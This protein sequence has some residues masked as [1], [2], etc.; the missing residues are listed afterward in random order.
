MIVHEDARRGQILSG[1]SSPDPAPDWRT[2]RRLAGRR[3]GN[4]DD[5]GR[6]T[7]PFDV[8][9]SE[10]LDGERDGMDVAS[11]CSWHSAVR[12]ST[13]RTSGRHDREQ[14]ADRPGPHELGCAGVRG[15]RGRVGAAPAAHQL[16]QLVKGAADTELD[17]SFRSGVQ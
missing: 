13:V 12:S 5:L 14:R 3:V 1:T 4:R 11:E 2:R 8:F 9:A 15:H 10:E 17:A 16:A 6:E 7:M